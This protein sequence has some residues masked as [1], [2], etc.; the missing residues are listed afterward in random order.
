MV[1]CESEAHASSKESC[2]VFDMRMSLEGAPCCSCN[3]A[4][5]AIKQNLGL[6]QEAEQ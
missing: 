5:D 3:H 6:D 4:G 1:W 2:E